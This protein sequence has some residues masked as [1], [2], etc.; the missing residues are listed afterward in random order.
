MGVVVAHPH[1]GPHQPVWTRARDVG[2]LPSFGMSVAGGIET[3]TRPDHIRRADKMIEK[4][5]RVEIVDR[6][7]VALRPTKGDRRNRS[8]GQRHTI[9]HDGAANTGFGAKFFGKT[10]YG[11]G[12]DRRYLFRPFRRKIKPMGAG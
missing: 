5:D 8:I 7:H 3:E 12:W 11:C 10:A 9:D 4:I 6:V 1:A 2:E